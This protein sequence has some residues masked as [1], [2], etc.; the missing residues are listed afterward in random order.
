MGC[1][2]KVWSPDQQEHPWELV[3]NVNTP[4]LLLLLSHF[5]GVGLY[6]RPISSKLH[7]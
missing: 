3:R 2:L 7:R 5:S 6:P 4:A 1:S